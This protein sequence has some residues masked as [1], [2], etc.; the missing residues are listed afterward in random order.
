[1]T[2]SSSS[3]E[4]TP[5]MALPSPRLLAPIIA[6]G[7]L[8][9]VFACQPGAAASQGIEAPQDAT[10]A[11]ASAPA[12]ST[13]CDRKSR[14]GKK[15]TPVSIRDLRYPF[16]SYI[17]AIHNRLHPRF[18]AFLKGLESLAPND[19]LSEPTL[20]AQVELVIDGSTGALDEICHL[21]TSGVARFDSAVM[22]VFTETFPVAPVP[23]EIVSEDAMVY[24][25]WELHRHMYYACSTYF[26]R[27]YKLRF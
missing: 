16:A 21:R 25:S 8:T 15:G 18:E 1:M 7:V 22:E 10:S 27:P 23:P 3:G 24:I 12:V 9:G 13:F 17:N 11:S 4:S 26:C 20:S 6:C 19:P 14:S 2:S 5:A